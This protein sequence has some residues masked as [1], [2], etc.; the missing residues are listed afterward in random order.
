MAALADDRRLFK[1]M[2]LSVFKSE[3]CGPENKMNV[4]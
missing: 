3:F 1:Q 4:S 2:W